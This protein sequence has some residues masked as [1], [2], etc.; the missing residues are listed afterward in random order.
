LEASIQLSEGSVLASDLCAMRVNDEKLSATPMTVQ[1]SKPV[2]ISGWVGDK[3]TMTWPLQPMLLL[4]HASST[5]KVWKFD[6]QAPI[7][8]SDVARRLDA[9]SMLKSGYVVDVDLS[10]IPDG[11]YRLYAAHVSEGQLYLCRR[12]GAL[13]I[14]R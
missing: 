8:R 14:S 1:A 9:P 4:E 2:E 13:T 12:G 6:L 5:A 10:N 3:A 7:E 11:N